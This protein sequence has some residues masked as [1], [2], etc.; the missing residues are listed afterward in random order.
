M[1][2]PA[3]FPDYLRALYALWDTKRGTRVMPARRDFATV[4][5]QPWLNELHLVAVSPEGLRFVVFASG[6]AS[7]Y[8]TEMTGRYVADLQPAAMA[9]EVERAYLTAV[10][11]RA[12]VF[13]THANR[14]FGTDSQTW[15][16]LILPLSDDGVRVD[17]LFVA[18]WEGSTGF[19]PRSRAHQA[20]L[21]SKWA[22]AET[23]E[24]PA[25]QASSPD[26][27]AA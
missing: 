11:T 27:A 25:P 2:L 12:P 19:G 17:R 6:P 22:L 4:E 18:V 10:E 24:A 21:T 13:G 5:L 7:R 20:L 8:G 15:S 16:R 23:F 26:L 1:S 3:S 9:D 14:G